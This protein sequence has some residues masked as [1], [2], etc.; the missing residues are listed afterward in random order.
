MVSDPLYLTILLTHRK[1]RPKLRLEIFVPLEHWSVLAKVA[2]LVTEETSNFVWVPVL[3]KL[4]LIMV[5][6]VNS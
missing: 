2:K 6:K 5:L 1:F 3:E 4:Q